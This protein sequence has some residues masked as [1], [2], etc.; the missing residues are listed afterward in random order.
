M[1]NLMIYITRCQEVWLAKVGLTGMFF[2][3]P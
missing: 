3:K 1:H 2:P